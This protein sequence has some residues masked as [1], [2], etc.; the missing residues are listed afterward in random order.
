MWVSGEV[1]HTNRGHKMPFLLCRAD[2]TSAQVKSCSA[3]WR[4]AG[5]VGPETW[6]WNPPVDSLQWSKTSPQIT[7][8]LQREQF[9]E[10]LIRS[11]KFQFTGKHK[12]KVF[13][14]R[15]ERMLQQQVCLTTGENKRN[16]CRKELSFSS[17]FLRG[18]FLALM[19]L[20]DLLPG[21]GESGIHWAVC[22]GVQGPEL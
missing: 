16:T 17:I 4:M 6:G 11:C 15:G 8:F 19:S 5:S 22:L 7:G 21:A 18:H 13:L 14:S 1:Q 9:G 20:V 12:K 10:P 2:P 3:L